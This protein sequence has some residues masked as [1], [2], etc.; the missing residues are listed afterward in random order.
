MTEFR[1]PPSPVR[2]LLRR[3]L[4]ATVPKMRLL[5]PLAFLLALLPASG[6]AQRSH[7]VRSGETLSHIARRHRVSIVELREA[8]NLRGDGVRVGQRLR[9]PGRNERRSRARRAGDHI[10][11]RGDTLTTI[12]RRYR[13]DVRSLRRANRLRG[14]RLRLGQRI[15]IPGRRRENHLPRVESL[16]LR[17]DQEA[18]A[19]RAQEFGL[20]TLRAGQNLLKDPPSDAWINLA[21][22][23]PLA[24]PEHALANPDDAAGTSA[25]QM[26]APSS[27]ASGQSSETES[28]NPEPRPESLDE[29]TD[30]EQ[31]SEDSEQ[32][33]GGR[34]NLRHAGEDTGEAGT[35]RLPIATAYY[36]RGWG[37]GRGGYHLAVDMGSPTG[38]P[39]LA[40]ERGVVAYAGHGIRGYGRFVM[41]VHPNGLVTAYA[42]NRELLVVPGEL[43][44]RGQP[45]ARLG[46][47]GISRG[48]H[49]HY[50]LMH[51]G[52]HC[53]PVPL[54][55]P[56]VPRRNG[57]AVESPV[58][59]WGEQRPEEVRCLPRSARPYPG[60]RRRP[61]RR[62]R[63]RRN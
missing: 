20:G 14:D 35:L 54:F 11:R 39:I 55:R 56:R 51:N 28:E 5:I 13:V 59:Q 31:T 37:S 18:A 6:M 15:R 24:I 9:I 63:N 8:N 16:S 23:A 17:P 60:A 10:V 4:R 29:A 44:A 43:V 57:A 47:T 25:A 3:H 42:H 22:E 48:P 12:A 50:M 45:I 34:A 61:Q 46:N 32:A 7:R 19:A 27:E 21:T 41:I 26:P 36:M 53:D 62:R 52:E 40:S 2:A 33:S 49:L 30:P 1:T 58:V 38:T